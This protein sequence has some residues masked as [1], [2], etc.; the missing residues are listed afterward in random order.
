[1]VCTQRNR[2]RNFPISAHRRLKTTP[3][4][5]RRL[6]VGSQGARD[7]FELPADGKRHAAADPDEADAEASSNRAISGIAGMQARSIRTW[8]RDRE[9]DHRAMPPKIRIGM[10]GSA[11][12]RELAGSTQRSE[13][14]R[15][16]QWRIRRR[17]IA[18]VAGS[19]SRTRPRRTRLS[20]NA[21]RR[22]RVGERS[23]LAESRSLDEAHRRADNEVEIG[24]GGYDAISW[25]VKARMSRGSSN[26]SVSD[27]E[28]DG[29]TAR[30]T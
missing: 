16:P 11:F 25:I 30:P 5:A 27:Q 15:E 2:P 24:V 12:L 26:R 23:L 22:I 3:S 29:N 17:V 28:V 6:I 18:R 10:C 14:R 4:A 8:R 7:L 1:M 20:A 13:S 21:I 19:S 9:A